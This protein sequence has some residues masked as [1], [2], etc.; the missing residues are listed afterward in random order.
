MERP[1]KRPRLS[2]GVNGEDSDDIDL[3]EAR[4]QNDLRLKSIFERIFEKYGKDFTDIGDEIDLQ[5]GKIVV[6]NGHLQRMSGEDDTG[7]KDEAGW[8]FKE[9]L[10]TS[11]V[12]ISKATLAGS[13]HDSEVETETDRDDTK[14]GVQLQRALTS[15]QPLPALRLDRA[16]DEKQPPE[17]G[18]A[19]S[20]DDS[21][22][23][24]SL[25]DCALIVP[26][27]SDKRDGQALPLESEAFPAKANTTANT[28]IQ[29][30][31]TRGDKADKP[32]E[33]IWRVPEIKGEFSTPIFYRS[34]PKLPLTAVRSGSPPKAGSLW[35]LPGQSR[36]NTDGRKE[37][38]RKKLGV[39]QRKYKHQSSPVLHD[40]SFAATPDGSESDDP[41]QED[42]QPSP[43]P[44]N[45][46]HIRAKIHVENT[47]SR[48]KDERRPLL[49]QLNP[50]SQPTINA[51][52]G[53]TEPK[54]ANGAAS[55]LEPETIEKRADQ[56]L[57]VDTHISAAEQHADPVIAQASTPTR[58]KR[59]LMTPDEAKLIIRMRQIEGKKWKEV[60][61][62]FPQRKLISLIQWN[63]TH[64][65]ER[66]DKPPR[67]SK[68]WS[69][70]E[71]DKLQAFKDQQGLTWPHIR[72]ALPGRSH[73]EIEF[74]LL[75]LWAEL[76]DCSK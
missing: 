11:T 25:L 44:K 4:A 52:H 48:T 1:Q 18:E 13:V 43:T 33:S 31:Q 7:A 8:L 73:A 24:D 28:P 53:A 26:N 30:Q 45:P 29:S 23:V 22:S 55:Q 62:H 19:D 15:P 41:L 67:I 69:K 17:T 46:I 74:A 63:Q 50:G 36:R 51:L 40:W 47:P 6:N 2:L 76:D 70:E 65:T 10:P 49:P 32:V 54:I 56:C 9:Q 37:K 27:D 3:Q 21:K 72:A 68:P 16:Y 61:E 14:D 57:S 42:Y 64:W 35:A 20:D 34:R 66:H 60:Q 71:V 58:A 39:S 59:T 12:Q 38:S 75:R 5:T